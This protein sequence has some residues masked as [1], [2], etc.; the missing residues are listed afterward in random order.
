MGRVPVEL[1]SLVGA[2]RVLDREL[3]QTEF[4]RKLVKLFLRWTAEIDPYS[5]LGLLEILRHVGDREAL[6]F[7]NAASVRPG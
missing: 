3:V 6:C 4:A 2:E 1:G 5:G 7:E